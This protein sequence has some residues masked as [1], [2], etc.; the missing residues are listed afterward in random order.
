MW[1]HTVSLPAVQAEFG[2]GRS[3]A[4]LP[5]TLAMIGFGVGGILMGR[6]MDRFGVMVAVILGSVL[7][8]V[9]YIAAGFAQNLLQYT[10]CYGLLIG[11]GTSAMFAPLLADISYWFH[12]RRGIAVS[13]AACGNAL[14][15]TIWPPVLQH[16]IASDGWRATHI[17]YG[18]VTAL[19][20]L[21]LSLAFRARAPQVP[22]GH[23]TAE[24]WRPKPITVSPGTLQVLLMM[25][26][27]GCCV[28]MATPQVHIVA[29]CGDL[30]Y[31]AARGAEM[32][33]L[34]LGMSV[35]SRLIAGFIAD[36]I[37]AMETLLLG[38]LL[39][40]AVLLLYLPFDGLTSLYIISA[41][42]GLFQ[43]GI[44]P[45]YA[46]VVRD[47]YPPNEAGR[48]VGTVI[49]ATLV[50]MALGGWLSGVIFD[51]TGSYLQA[52]ANGLLWNLMNIAII[53]FLIC[54]ARMAGRK[55]HVAPGP[56]PS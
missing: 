14:S 46:L 30:G 10:L 44:I 19:L 47:Y 21:P 12:R 55:L 2:A 33:A 11:L 34:M 3:D 35:V 39:Q 43:G 51:A 8:S 25:A 36:R 23:A 26:G 5:Y 17:G 29:Y 1:S 48:R 6:I 53:I 31:G 18:V 32:L 9:G 24:A 16:F 15:G 56:C 22:L 20:L 4:A 13:I 45:M 50:G 52:F 38:S 37:G 41:M 54:S 27:V 42:F 49:M 40:A 7:I 28:A